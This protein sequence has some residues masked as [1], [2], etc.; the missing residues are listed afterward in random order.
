MAQAESDRHAALKQLA[1]AWARAEGF[2]I[3]GFE[4][5]L[6]NCGYR[7]DVAAYRPERG[8]TPGIGATAVFECKQARSDFQ[9]DSH[10]AEPTRARLKTLDARRLK[11]E[12]L[13]R[14]HHPELRRSE[15]LFEA[16]DNYDFTKLGHQT[17]E[18]IVR[19]IGVLQNRL[20]DR[21]KFE[22]LVRYRCAN[23]FCL[24]VADGV[25]AEHESPP[26]W[27]LLVHRADRLELLRKPVWHDCAEP[28]RLLVL[29]RIAMAGM[30][31][32][33]SSP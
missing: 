16:F 3:C 33:T 13:L 28:N 4:V 14:V 7:A 30:R 23:L 32:L 25:L 24:V 26:G 2:S 9:R 27:G 29:Q 17:W 1:V 22:K 19:E 11:L 5:R 6:P 15:T 31:R 20:Y 21:T 18:R 10:S 8:R 12:E